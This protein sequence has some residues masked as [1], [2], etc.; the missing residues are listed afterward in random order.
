MSTIPDS[1]SFTARRPNAQTLPQFELPPPPL[2]GLQTRFAQHVPSYS[3][4]TQPTPTTATTLTSVGNLLTPPS[5]SADGLSPASGMTTASSLSSQPYTPNSWQ[6]SSTSATA[7]YGFNSTAQFGRGNIFS[8]SLG[9]MV[10]SSGSPTATEGLPPPPYE[11]PQYSS[12]MP[13]SAPNLPAAAHSQQQHH[14]IG[15]GMM[16]GS[17]P[18]SAVTQASPVHSQDAFARP[19]PT[20][21]Y[22]SQPSSTPQQ[23]TF[24]Y[25]TGPSPVQQSPISG[26]GPMPRQ[27]PINGPGQM[28]PLPLS[29]PSYGHPRPFAPSY[30]S[31]IGPVLSNVGNPGGQLALVNGMGPGM[32][33]P[34]NSGHA[35]MHQMYP[36]PAQPNPANDRPF[37]CDQCPQSFNRNHDLKRHKRI[38][39]A[40]KPFPC[41]HCDK[42][43]SRKDALKVRCTADLLSLQRLLMILTETRPRQRLRQS[44]RHRRS[45]GAR[46]LLLS[47]I[48]EWHQPSHHRLRIVKRDDNRAH[49][50]PRIAHTS[51]LR[52]VQIPF[53]ALYYLT[54]HRHDH[55]Y[56]E[57]TLLL[58]LL[59]NAHLMRGTYLDRQDRWVAGMAK[60]IMAAFLLLGSG[61]LKA[62]CGGWEHGAF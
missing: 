1:S 7:P 32:G 19:P 17:A 33:M 43:F 5:N 49:Q 61:C 3:S 58:P 18:A 35:A 50:T 23:T 14:M 52:I 59:L 41:G 2:A 44:P 20:P 4:S 53:S 40:V 45:K 10:R 38:H 6:P 9:S 28:Q 29:I 26:P 39:L 30:P 60:R 56:H 46:W 31:P 8:P 16:G 36:H 25:S 48:Q 62:L 15:N 22:Y 13:M 12:S 42:S 11:L 24:P 34:Y 37:R 27:S 54:T 55:V 51:R 47:R 21:S 57:A